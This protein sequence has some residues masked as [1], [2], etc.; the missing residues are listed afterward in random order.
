MLAGAS[1]L[2]SSI[3]FGF[4]E[5]ARGEFLLS[6]TARET[7]DSRIFGALNSAD[8]YIFTLDPR[9]IYR[10]EA[11]RLKLDALAGLRINRYHEF[12]ELNSEDVES[13]LKL[14]LPASDEALSSGTFEVGYN[15]RTDVNFDVNRSLREKTF[16]SRLDTVI[17][18]GL[19]TALL[20]GGSYRN[21]QRNAFSDLEMWNG[22]IGFRY[23]NFLE[24]TDFDVRYRRLQAKTSGGNAFSVP[25]HQNTDIFS[26]GISRPL[27]HDVRASFTYGYRILHRS[28]AEVLSG[29]ERSAGSIISIN[30]DGPLLPASKF[31]KLESSLSLGYQKAE[32]PGVH[33]TGGTRFV[34]SAR[35]SWHARER[36]RIFIDARRSRQLTADDLTVEATEAN[37]G[38][39]ESIGDFTFASASIGYERRD[40]RPLTRQD[41][42]FNARL[43]AG[44]RITKS[45]SA[46]A[47][48]RL[49]SA[50]S[51]SHVADYARHLVMLSV[52]YIF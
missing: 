28:Q 37:I 25:L 1:T 13:S 48:Y 7:Y 40:Y 14:T 8:D 33:D 29:Q 41:D 36:T 44:Y 6:T 18:T 24:G 50:S 5:F 3:A 11:A 49:R 35:L 15:E 43:G 52:T 31:P 45:W 16:D 2:G 32:T 17:P 22:N 34:G 9:L 23:R 30:L 20:L 21:D 46:S 27:Y 10:R 19:K 38:V 4:A 47:D 51:S 12:T 26:V 39:S 42:V